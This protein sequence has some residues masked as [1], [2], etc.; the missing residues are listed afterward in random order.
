MNKHSSCCHSI[1]HLV[2][3]SRERSMRFMSRLEM[4]ALACAWAPDTPL[5]TWMRS[6][7]AVLPAPSKCTCS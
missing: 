2:M 6:R 5:S 4:A 3:T 1:V 7:Q